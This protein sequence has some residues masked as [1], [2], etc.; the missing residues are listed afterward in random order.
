MLNAFL[1]VR[2]PAGGTTRVAQ[3]ASKAVVTVC[4]RDHPWRWR[5]KVVAAELS[6]A[7]KGLLPLSDCLEK[8]RASCVVCHYSF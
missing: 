1:I 3:L 2:S 7:S 5:Q 4:S 8:V 6:A